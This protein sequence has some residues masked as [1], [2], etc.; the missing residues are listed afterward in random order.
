M[1]VSVLMVGM[2]KIAVSLAHRESTVLIVLMTASVK[3]MH[4]AM[5]K[6]D[7]AY[8]TMATTEHCKSLM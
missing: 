7:L 1:L 2:D 8:V 6:T 3:T 5:R 4:T